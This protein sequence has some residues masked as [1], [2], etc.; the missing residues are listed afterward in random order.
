MKHAELR[1]VLLLCI[2]YCS[3]IACGT[4]SEI[5]SIKEFEIA[6]QYPCYVR[7]GW[8]GGVVSPGEEV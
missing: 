2:L 3:I 7:A 6:K 4:P 5:T 8:D 1:V